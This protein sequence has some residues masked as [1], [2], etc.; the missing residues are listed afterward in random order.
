MTDVQGLVQ[1]Q[2]ALGIELI[3]KA[4]KA[5]DA[6]AATRATLAEHVDENLA[7]HARCA[8]LEAKLT[9]TERSHDA[10][11]ALVD[12]RAL[13][14]EAYQHMP[15]RLVQWYR[16]CKAWLTANPESPH[17]DDEFSEPEALLDEVLQ[18][19]DLSR[20]AAHP[21]RDRVDAW[22]KRR[23]RAP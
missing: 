12:A 3:A 5:E 10:M 14:G 16:D 4:A 15:V 2:T 11:D 19:A 9:A 8:E 21:L 13:L 22:R 20:A 7:L 18:H 6:L 17:S 23:C 1:A